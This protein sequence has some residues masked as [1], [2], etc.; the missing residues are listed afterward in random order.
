KDLMLANN[1]WAVNVARLSPR[2]R[3]VAPVYGDSPEELTSVAK[4]LID[5]GIRA[6]QLVSG[7]LP[8]GVS[9]ASNELDRFYA[10][11]AEAKVPITF[12]IG[13]ELMFF[14]TLGWGKAA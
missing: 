14:D 4:S 3:P 5:R 12:H 1:E 9:P 7:R 11:L 2:L 10:M 13:G 6:V 8:G